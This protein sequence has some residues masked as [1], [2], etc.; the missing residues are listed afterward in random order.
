MACRHA[1]GKIGEERRDLRRDREARIGIAHALEILLTRLLN[2]G[3]PH[4]QIGAEPPDRDRDDVG[5]DT[6]AL[7][8][9][10]DEDPQSLV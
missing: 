9:A 5:E 7:A 10:D 2:E 3:K 1:R 4:A 8:A 6:R